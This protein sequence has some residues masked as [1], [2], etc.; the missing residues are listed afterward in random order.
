[1]ALRNSYA[2]ASVSTSFTVA[3]IVRQNSLSA[4]RTTRP[5]SHISSPRRLAGVESACSGGGER[6]VGVRGDGGEEHR[7]DGEEDIGWAEVETELGERGH[8]ERRVVSAR[9]RMSQGRTDEP[10]ARRE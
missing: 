9:Q 8:G 10:V 2:R 4:H 1:M 6:V 5:I 7:E 3:S